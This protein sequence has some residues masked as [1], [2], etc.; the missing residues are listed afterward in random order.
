MRKSFRFIPLLFIALCSSLYAGAQELRANVSVVA[1]QVGTSVDRKVFVTLQNQLNEFLNNRRWTDDSYTQA[2]RIDCNFIINVQSTAGNNIYKAQIT[3]QA[4][5][6]VFNSSYITSTFNTLD[7]NVAFKYVE[8]QSIEFNEN[9]VA[10]NDALVSNLPATLAY[11][12]YMILGMD[13]DSFSLRGGDPYFKKAQTIVNGAPDGKEISGWKAFEGNRNRYWLQDNIL[14]TK[15]TR[16]HEAMYLYHR[17]GLDVMY[18]D[19]T[20]GR[21]A[22]LNALGLLLAIHEDTPNTMLLATFFNAKADELLRVFSKAP[23]QEKQ[24]ASAMLQRMDVPNAQKY[25]QLK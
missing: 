10:G 5:R 23:P 1:N 24:R 16:F 8:F 12:V 21:A 9:R 11:Y 22:I 18:D 20:K 17:Q 13:N 25:A 2:E 14:N 6:P 15:F 3:V 4:T 7:G 19:V